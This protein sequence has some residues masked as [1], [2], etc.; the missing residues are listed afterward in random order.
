MD[1]AQYIDHTLLKPQASRQDVLALCAEAAQ[2]GVKSVCVN[3][4]W[5]PTVHEALAGSGVL[6]CA[7]AGFPLG[8]TTTAVKVAEAAGAVA[9]GAD[10]VDMVIDI[11]AALAGDREALVADIG[12]VARAV[13]E[14]GAI[15]K[16]II[17][18]CLLDEAAKELACRAAVE[19]GADFV[20]TSTGFSTGG[21]TVEDVA[22]MRRVVGPDV[23]VKASGGVRTR[24]DALA[25]IEAGATRIGASSALAILKT[26]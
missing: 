15:L 11:A 9:D 7:V 8:A 23:G 5:V 24:E 21:A 10:E 1:L 26:N 18:T 6:T 3:P 17:E 22:L 4:V 16:V 14:G 25:M 2:A 13:H 12:A 20:K 19:A